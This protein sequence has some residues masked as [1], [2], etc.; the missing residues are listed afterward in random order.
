MDRRARAVARAKALQTMTRVAEEEARARAAEQRAAERRRADWERRRQ[1]RRARLE[2]QRREVGG[3]ID[4]V[5]DRL[6]A[7]GRQRREEESHNEELRQR[8]LQLG[9]QLSRSVESLAAGR[10][11]VEAVARQAEKSQG[12]LAE[13]TREVQTLERA[14]KEAKEARERQQRTYS[15][16][17]YHGKR[18]D[19][20]RPV[21][22]E[23]TPAGV[24]FHPEKIPL[25]GP[26]FGP[27]A[28]RA[29]VERRV[30]RLAALP[31]AGGEKKGQAAAYLLFLIRPDG[32]D[33]YYRAVNS[34]G[35]LEFDFGYEFID[36]DW[37]LDFP[38]EDGTSG[39][40]PWM[41]AEKPDPVPAEGAGGKSAP[42]PPPRGLPWPGG[43]PRGVAFGKGVS[44][45]GIEAGGGAEGPPLSV[46]P[47]P[48]RPGPGTGTAGA[49]DV[50][51]GK[52]PAASAPQ[53]WASFNPS[54]PGAPGT[55]GAAPGNG[56]GDTTAAAPG[57][58]GPVGVAGVGSGNGS[59]QG[60]QPA[61]GSGPP[62]EGN[63]PDAGQR[64]IASSPAR[65]GAQAAAAPGAPGAGLSGESYND[66]GGTPEKAPGGSRGA[67]PSGAAGET[68]A[69]SPG[70]SR[71]SG[72]RW[73]GGGA[74]RDGDPD[75]PGRMPGVLPSAAPAKSSG[76]P[77]PSVRV[78]GNRDWI[79]RVECLADAVVL[80]PSGRR[81]L[82]A[83]LAR[84]QGGGKE[85]VQ[86]VREMIAR[87]QAGVRPGE[88]P[89]RPQ[90]RFLVRP[91]GLRTFFLAYPVLEAVGVPMNRQ[92]LERGEEVR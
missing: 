3:R 51:P 16:V 25:E 38:A 8:L 42:R 68:R 52:I 90:V 43:T 28:F 54:G 18:G 13:L 85:L 73:G 88:L 20:R 33:N 21:Y 31:E 22:V 17:P 69:G 57:D 45:S 30:A 9:G 5:Q 86:A 56:A 59:G 66:P 84:D 37:V 10:G 60:R 50:T 40:R 15:L 39:K 24:V 14:L 2:Q 63:G 49:R 78:V 7:A 92:D 77:G 19:S 58:G 82:A 79:L 55:P 12:E 71:S 91:D 1:D 70:G 67:L 83:T 4:A 32:I 26:G 34:L 48:G 80:Y 35:G 29:E 76:A 53:P 65:T 74:G 75:G 41:A 36:P 61:V 87:R 62:G 6:Q 23:C 47:G 72:V 46:H 44:G 64:R 11:K 27:A 81:F 89:Y